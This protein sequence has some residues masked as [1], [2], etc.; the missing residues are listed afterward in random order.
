[1]RSLAS[2]QKVLKVRPIDGADKIEAIDVLGWTVVS[3]K[4]RF[5]EGDLCIYF[6]VDSFLN[7][8]DPRY[9]SFSERFTNWDGKR[10]MR[11]KTIRLRKQLSQGLILKI[12]E[13]PEIF[14]PQEGDDVTKLL[15][16]EQWYNPSEMKE[17]SSQQSTSNTRQ[18]PSF[19]RKTD[20]ERVQNYINHLSQVMDETFEATIKLDG[21]SMTVFHLNNKSKYFKEAL[22]ER[23]I[24]NRLKGFAKLKHIIKTFFSRFNQPIEINGVCSRNIQLDPKGA[25][26]FSEYVRNHNIFEALDNADINCAIQGELL[27]VG[28]QNNYEAVKDFEFYVY[29]IFNIDTQEYLLPKEA[30]ELTAT[31]G[32]AYVPLLSEELSI[33]DFNKSIEIRDMVEN[34]LE[35]AEGPGM[36]AGVKREGV[37]FKSNQSSASFKAISNSYLLKK[38]K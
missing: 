8:D 30:R 17:N 16:I 12:S 24:K 10:G 26:H 7:A 35:Y 29:D 9:A 15:K 38:D 27:G 25:N 18:F 5:K 22:A 37:V 36:N 28:I 33:K 13:F 32:L 6:E 4:G 23:A 34:I 11:L 1:M 19:I 20:Q 2:I 3:E 21:S 31:L 14:T